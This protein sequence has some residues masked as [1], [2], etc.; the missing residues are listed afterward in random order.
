[1]LPISYLARARARSII[2]ISTVLIAI[3][4]LH[5]CF[6]VNVEKMEAKG[7]WKKKCWCKEIA[8]A[9]TVVR[10]NRWIIIIGNSH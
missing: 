7:E 9:A 10:N 8:A 4:K 5:E 1:M 3:N 2:L 6:S